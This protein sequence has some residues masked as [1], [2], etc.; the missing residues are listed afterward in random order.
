APRT[1]QNGRPLQKLAGGGDWAG[2]GPPPPAAVLRAARP[3]AGA[4]DARLSRP[5]RDRAPAAGW[6]AVRDAQARRARACARR[7]PPPAAARRAGRR[8]EPRGGWRAR[9]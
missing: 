4:R 7:A 2:R 3:E 1:L 6:P 9:G 5:R 8:V